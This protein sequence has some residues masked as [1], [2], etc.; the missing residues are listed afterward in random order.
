MHVL[1]CVGSTEKSPHKSLFA[2]FL[3]IH[4]NCKGHFGRDP[5]DGSERK[6]SGGPITD[7]L[8]SKGL[9]CWIRESVF[10]TFS[11]LLWAVMASVLYLKHNAKW[12]LNIEI[13]EKSYRVSNKKPQRNPSSRKVTSTKRL[14]GWYGK[15]FRW[16][17][18]G[19]GVGIAGLESHTWRP[20][21][22]MS[23]ASS[24]H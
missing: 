1:S 12:N 21:H 18:R 16:V 5:I 4:E 17:L 22:F 14:W 9:P 24:Y 13:E 11:N 6:V 2:T 7:E 10:H 20:F 23:R 19:V 3:D 15:A 8:Y